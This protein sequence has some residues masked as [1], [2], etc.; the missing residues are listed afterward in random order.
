MVSN[1][2]TALRA[3]LIAKFLIVG[4][5]TFISEYLVFYMLF[6]FLRWDLLLANSLSFGVGLSLSFLLNRTWAFRQD[7]YRRKIHHQIVIYISL[8]CTNLVINNLIVSLL[9]AWGLDPR[10]GKIIA[11]G[12]IAIWNFLIYKC[13]IFSTHS[14][15]KSEVVEN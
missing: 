14:S 1:V 5:L 12:A 9:R 13:L 8:A 4:S 15:P 7:N 10:F 11:I 2:F 3:S 6:I